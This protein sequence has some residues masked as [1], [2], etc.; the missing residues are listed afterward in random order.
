MI[1]NLQTLIEKLK[2]YINTVYYTDVNINI[3]NYNNRGFIIQSNIQEFRMLVSSWTRY[4]NS[5][6]TGIILKYYDGIEGL[7]GVKV[8]Q[9]GEIYRY[10]WYNKR[11]YKVY[12]EYTMILNKDMNV[13]RKL[14]RYIIDRKT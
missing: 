9:Q 5:N 1:E 3:V 14:L 13:Q 8:Y 6:T 10:L 7:V 11:W 12:R 2:A 4:Y